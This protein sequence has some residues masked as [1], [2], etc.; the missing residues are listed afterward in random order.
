MMSKKKEVLYNLALH[1]EGVNLNFIKM[2]L[3]EIQV[4]ELSPKRSGYREV[5]D[6]ICL[7][8][9]KIMYRPTLYVSERYMKQGYLFI[10]QTHAYP[11]DSCGMQYWLSD[12]INEIHQRQL[13]AEVR[14]KLIDRNMAKSQL[15]LLKSLP[16]TSYPHSIPL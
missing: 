7:D 6:L 5:I 12:V 16:G 15:R 2:S 11:C 14:L 9:T 8:G 4:V 13:F 1:L 3:K 10:A